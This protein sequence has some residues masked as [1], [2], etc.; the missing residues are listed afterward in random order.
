M[1]LL[2]NTAEPGRAAIALAEDDGRVLA[3]HVGP[4]RRGERDTLLSTVDRVLRRTRRSLSRVRG[5]A[6][7]TGP[8]P[9]SGLRAG[10]ATANALGFSLGVRVVGISATDASTPQTFAAVALQRFTSTRAGAWVT[11]EYGAEPHITLKH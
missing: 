5:V 11:P 2:I 10:I 8:G 6:V 1:L 3:S 9:F 4:S 7:V